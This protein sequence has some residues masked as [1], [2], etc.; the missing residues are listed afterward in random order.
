MEWARTIV[1]V[2]HR[3]FLPSAFWHAPAVDPNFEHADNT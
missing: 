1:H 2:S 3:W